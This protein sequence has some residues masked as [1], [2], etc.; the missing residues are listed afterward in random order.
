MNETV[1]AC[2]SVIRTS[3]RRAFKKCRRAWDWG[4]REGWEPKSR[5]MPFD[6]GTA[7]HAGLQVYYNPELKLVIPKHRIAM[8]VGAFIQVMNDQYER[9]AN[10]VNSIDQE[11]MDSWSDHVRLGKGM[12][13]D[14][15]EYDLVHHRFTPIAVETTFDIPI[16]GL[17]CDCHGLPVLYEIRFDVLAEDED[18]E[19]ILVDHKTTDNFY[20]DTEEF[21]ALDEQMKSYA[22]GVWARFG[23]RVSGV[24]YNELKKEIP[25]P[26]KVLKNRQLSI[27]K[28][29]NTS[30]KLYLQAI[31]ATGQRQELYTPF[32]EYLEQNP[33][34]RFRH[35]RIEYNTQ[36]LNQQV[37]QIR[38]EAIEMI[39]P[40][41]SVYP[42]PSR[43]NCRTCQF[44][45]PCLMASEGSDAR[46]LLNANYVHKGDEQ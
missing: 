30:L 33:R 24:V 37:E 17:I 10:L 20:E 22:W 38:N 45:A 41:I 15:A 12:L 7:I 26:P 46:W 29:Q 11:D 2:P 34:E 44:K 32:L 36:E 28:R 1:R 3:H 16:P 5:P 39:N 31:R 13:T 25:E 8:A 19:L 42:N 35:F 23:R 27:D 18:S 43:M 6:F 9:F 4:V 14:Y 21:L 40:N